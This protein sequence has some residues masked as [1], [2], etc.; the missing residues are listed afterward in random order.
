MSKSVELAE[1]QNWNRTN[2]VKLLDHG[3]GIYDRVSTTK[4]YTDRGVPSASIFTYYGKPIAV[5]STIAKGLR[6]LSDPPENKER[7]FESMEISITTAI[8]M[9]ILIAIS[10]ILLLCCC[11]AYLLC[12]KQRAT[13]F[14]RREDEVSFVPRNFLALIALVH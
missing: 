2:E 13:S 5:G 11:K 3:M 1:M 4:D 10:A 8:F 14:R 7:A 6:T 9:V 12:C